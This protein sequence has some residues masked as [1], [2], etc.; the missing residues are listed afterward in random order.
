M[1]FSITHSSPTMAPVWSVAEC[2]SGRNLS[3]LAW[4]PTLK[5]EIV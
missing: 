2:I 1:L 4:L 3:G 5:E